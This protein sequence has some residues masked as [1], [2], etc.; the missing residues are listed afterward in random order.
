ML[1]STENV[2]TGV[3]YIQKSVCV[4]V[5]IIH[6][7]HQLRDLNQ[8]AVFNIEKQAR[9]MMQ[10]RH[11]FSCLTN[12]LSHSSISRNKKLAL[13]DFWSVIQGASR[14]NDECTIRVRLQSFRR[15]LLSLLMC[16][17]CVKVLEIW[18]YDCYH[19]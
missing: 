14:E 4:F 2:F 3:S 10:A 9:R 1:C 6:I 17:L 5:S 12:E 19:V 15:Y 16:V 8:L 13:R 18:I 11:L 7:A